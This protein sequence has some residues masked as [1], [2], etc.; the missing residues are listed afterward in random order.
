V[1]SND[2]VR[3]SFSQLN[4]AAARNQQDIHKAILERFPE[5]TVMVPKARLKIWEPEQYF[6][7]LFNTVAMYLSWQGQLSADDKTKSGQ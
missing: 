5:L 3:K 7:P 2:T 1:V 4:G 6:T